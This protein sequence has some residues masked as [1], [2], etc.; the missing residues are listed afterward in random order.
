MGNAGGARGRCAARHCAP[1]AADALNQ[2]CPAAAEAFVGC[3]GQAGDGMGADISAEVRLAQT[4][5]DRDAVFAVGHQVFVDEQSVPEELGYDE[6]D[7]ASDH[8]LALL[9]RV[10]AGTGWLVIIGSPADAD[11]GRVTKA[12]DLGSRPA[13]PDRRLRV[14]R[15]QLCLVPESSELLGRMGRSQH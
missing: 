12:T 4:E 14:R 1:R 7:L 2:V 3:P 9:D 6:L 5:A 8:F 10:P 11:P 15:L 13:R